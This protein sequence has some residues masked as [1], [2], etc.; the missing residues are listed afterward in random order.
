M[1]GLP[2]T[3]HRYFETNFTVLTPSHPK[4]TGIAKTFAVAM[5]WEY[6]DMSVT[7]KGR[8]KGTADRWKKI[9]GIPAD[10]TMT[11][12]QL[13]ECIPPAYAEFIG[14]A[15]IAQH[16]QALPL[17]PMAGWQRSWALGVAD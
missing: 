11:Q 8:R 6:R 13:A 3:R 7:G 9:L 4:C 2:T 14:K 17:S 10:A 16:H 5:G 15:W 1:F 12:H